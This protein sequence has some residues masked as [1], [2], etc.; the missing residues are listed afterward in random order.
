MLPMVRSGQVHRHGAQG[1]IQR[2]AV[3]DPR[4]EFLLDSIA[5]EV[6]N[7]TGICTCSER[8]A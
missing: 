6:S 5:M 8:D 1:L 2:R 7:R 4:V 3:L